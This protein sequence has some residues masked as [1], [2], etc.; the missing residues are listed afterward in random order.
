MTHSVDNVMTELGELQRSSTDAAKFGAIRVK[1]VGEVEAVY[2]AERNKLERLRDQLGEVNRLWEK[3]GYDTT[4]LTEAMEEELDELRR[5]RDSDLELAQIGLALN[6]ISH[7]FE[8]TVGSLRDGF[9]R[10]KAWADENP[11]LRTLYNNMRASF[12]H[13][14]E[15]LTL[16]IP[17]DR[18]SHRTKVDIS[19]KQIFEFLENLFSARLQRHTVKL[20][21]T[22]AFLKASIVSYPSSIY[23]VFVNLVDNAVFWLQRRPSGRQIELDSIGGDFIVRDNGPGVSAR[24]RENIFALNFS[25]KPGGRG[26]G[27]HISRETLAKVDLQL[28]LDRSPA[29]GAAFRISALKSSREQN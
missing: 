25:R 9:R 2:E 3:D 15:Y 8:K 21:A 17:L 19:G 23:P 24:D 4:E 28:T 1:L 22:K 11:D 12:D 16:F 26:M 10:L 14:D 27:L 6:T 18:R 5:R 29:E 7:E 13:L 20:A